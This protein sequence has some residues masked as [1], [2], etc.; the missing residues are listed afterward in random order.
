MPSPHARE[1]TPPGEP[2]SLEAA[3]IDS[4]PAVIYATDL[5]GKY[6]AVNRA[7]EDLTRIPRQSALSKSP[8]EICRGIEPGLDPRLFHS[9]EY[10]LK[11]ANGS[12]IGTG[13]I[14]IDIREAR[15]RCEAENRVAEQTLRERE[16]ALE[17]SMEQLHALAQGLLLMDEEGKK[18]L[19]RDL[20]DDLSQRLAVIALDADS[21]ALEP[22][23]SREELRR[24]LRSFER[25]VAELSEDVRRMAHQLRPSI[26]DD[27]GLPAALHA[28]CND[29]SRREQITV[30]CAVHRIPASIPAGAALCLYRVAQEALRNVAKHSGAKRAFGR[31]GARSGWLWLFI[32]DYGAGFDTQARRKQGL[33]IVIMEERVRLAGGFFS[34]RSR[35]RFGTRIAVRVP[36]A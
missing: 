10:P 15:Q 9:V 12:V 11:D 13:A 33:G 5:S 36:I 8:A 29:F 4:S 31:L 6:I 16:L 26:L 25:R 34:L 19:S 28:Y 18:A 27:L 22:P 17:R 20:H 14:S 32:R 7:W 30:V 23:K 21:L 35:P 24:R 2:C 1:D 3:I